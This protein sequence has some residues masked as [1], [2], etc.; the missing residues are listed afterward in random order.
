MS[1][2]TTLN[3]PCVN[4]CRLEDEFRE[5]PGTVFAVLD[6]ICK[7]TQDYP[8]SKVSAAREVIGGATGLVQ[9]IQQPTQRGEAARYLCNDQRPRENCNTWNTPWRN[10]CNGK[11]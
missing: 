1:I 4:G 10:F 2:S 11:A 8:F 6:R 9:Y 7:S 3:L 5:K